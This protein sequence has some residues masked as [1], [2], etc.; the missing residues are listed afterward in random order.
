MVLLEQIDTPIE[1]K[2]I[3]SSFGFATSTFVSMRNR[4]Y[5]DPRP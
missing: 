1:E 5:A 3:K 4:N 2:T